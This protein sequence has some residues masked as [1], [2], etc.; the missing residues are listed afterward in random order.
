MST[1]PLF[2][3]S[4]E[5]PLKRLGVT[6]SVLAP[7]V[8]AFIL[9]IRWMH[10]RMLDGISLHHQTLSGWHALPSPKALPKVM[11]VSGQ[12]MVWVLT[13]ESGLCH[14]DGN[15]WQYSPDFSQK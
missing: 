10:S 14:W 9:E 12:G 11:Y 2:P 13:I 8:L 1:S 7:V 6:L 3:G 5:T 15:S 4:P